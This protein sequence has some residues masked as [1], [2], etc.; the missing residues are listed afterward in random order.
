ML[1]GCTA[2]P[3]TQE[4]SSVRIIDNERLAAEI[5]NSCKWLGEVNGTQ[6]NYFTAD[7]TSESNMM[8]GSRNS[9]R[10]QAAKIGANTVIIQRHQSVQNNEFIGTGGHTFIG[11]AFKCSR[12]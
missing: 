2:A 6:G 12:E 8:A 11:Q 1:S 7:F 9:L 4:G 3:L 5:E 10:N